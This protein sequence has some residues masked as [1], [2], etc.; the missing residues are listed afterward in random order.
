MISKSTRVEF[1]TSGSGTAG[2]GSCSVSS[3][4]EPPPLVEGAPLLAGSVASFEPEQLDSSN[5]KM[6][7]NVAL[8]RDVDALRF[9][10]MSIFSNSFVRRGWCLPETLVC[11]V[12][13]WTENN[14]PVY[15]AITQ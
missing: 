15:S 6:R 7:S 14:S 12:L 3:A 4:I 2:S 1:C 13:S 10:L 5:V 11:S 9:M 8:Q